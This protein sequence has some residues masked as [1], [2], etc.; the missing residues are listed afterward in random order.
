MMIIC[1]INGLILNY[2]EINTQKITLMAQSKL[3]L[4]EKFYIH[5]SEYNK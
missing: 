2:L 1:Q 4:W 3:L 5:L